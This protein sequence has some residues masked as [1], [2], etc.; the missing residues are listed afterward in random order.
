[1][2]GIIYKVTGPDGLVY[3]G[4]TVKSLTERKGHHAYSAIKGDRRSPFC[5][6]L[7]EKGVNA[8]QWEQIDS[9]ESKEELDE[10]EKQWIAHYQSDNPIHGYNSTSGGGSY[11][12]SLEHRQKV[13]MALTGKKLSH[14]H[15]RKLS[16]AKK[17]KRPSAETIRKRVESR[18]GYTHSEETRRKISLTQ[19]GKVVSE[20][21]R[22]KLRKAMTGK[23]HTL[24]T[25]Q[26]LSELGK[27]ECPWLRGQKHS[28]EHRKKISEGVKRFHSQKREAQNG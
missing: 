1:M 22:C 13:S 14:E 19:I 3:I 16:E 28:Q 18:K 7:L 24:E 8:F 9:A 10:K 2:Y 5:I 23:H 17:G 27:R 20:E 15:R 25:R 4:Q 26:K 21:T 12:A 6:A 11:K